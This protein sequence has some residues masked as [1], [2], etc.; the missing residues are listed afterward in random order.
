MKKGESQFCYRN[1]TKL[2]RMRNSNVLSIALVLRL[3]GVLGLFDE[4]E[5]TRLLQVRTWPFRFKWIFGFQAISV[6]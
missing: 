5:C 6:A 2:L 3:T 1:S 4:C